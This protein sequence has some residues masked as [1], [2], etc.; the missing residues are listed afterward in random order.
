MHKS[1]LNYRT[2]FFLALS[3]SLL[4]NMLSLTTFFFGK[5]YMTG[6]RENLFLFFRLDLTLL[7][8]FFNFIVAF[9]LYFLNFYLLRNN[10]FRKYK[11]LLIVLATFVCTVIISS[12]TTV[13]QMQFEDFWPMFPRPFPVIIWGSLLRDFTIAIVVLL[14]SQLLYLTYKQQQTNLEN[15][16][17]IAENMK[18]RFMALKNQVDPHF[19]FNS[20]NT[21]NSLIKLD[22]DKAQEYVQKL[23]NVFRYTLQNKE[24]ISLEEELKFTQAY[25]HLM[26]I[27]FGNSLQ[28]VYQVDEK[29]SAYSIIPLSLQ[30]LVENA[31]KHN[32]ISN[33]QPLLITIS[34][35]DDDYVLVS[36]PVQPKKEPDRGEGIGLANLEERYRL[37]W[38]KNIV[39]NQTENVFEVRIPL[40]GI[41]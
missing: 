25:A 35:T 10:V 38:K 11:A 18:T 34:T 8:I 26:Q 31:I 14:S 6:G 12:L 16:T 40:N 4:M 21:L 29:Y 17:L 41:D 33:R 36:N 7:R 3:I 27:R 20:L 13:I 30:T 37:M 32:I 5:G 23:S 9:T 19:L 28:F 22:A 2:A 15:E 24:V 1:P 39:V